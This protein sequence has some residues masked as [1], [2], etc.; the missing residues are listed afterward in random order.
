MLYIHHDIEGNYFK[1]AKAGEHKVQKDILLSEIAKMVAIC[2]KCVVGLLNKAGIKTNERISNSALVKAVSNALN[3]N[4]GFARMLIAEILSKKKNADG[5]ARGVTKAN[6]GPLVKGVGVCF[7][8]NG[9]QA[10]KDNAE[11]DLYSK[12]ESIRKLEGLTSNAGK[13]IVWTLLISS[14]VGIGYYCYKN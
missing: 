2:P 8:A 10:N 9:N 5:T 3:K 1:A 6:V 11:K 13:Y 7:G 14:V 4:I 12:T